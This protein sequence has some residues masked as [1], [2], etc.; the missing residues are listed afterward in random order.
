MP[1]RLAIVGLVVLCIGM[2]TQAKADLVS[3]PF[4]TTTP[5]PSTLTD[6]TSSLSFPQFDSSLGTLTSVELSLT[7]HFSTV[8]TV[9][10]V[11]SSSST[12][13]AK[14][15]V[16]VTVQDSGGNL[17]IPELDLFSSNYAFT[18][19]PAGQYITSGTINKSGGSSDVYTSPAVLAEFTGPGTIVL[20]AATYTQS[21]IA[22]SGGNS[23]AAQVTNADLT[24]SVKYTYIPVPEPS[25][26]LLLGIGTLGLLCCT[27]RGRKS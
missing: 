4:T 16:Q 3:G 1:H 19:L 10:N 20:P 25:T 21:W 27:R 9:T 18:N 26:I 12:G 14:T 23:L 24:G 7:G 17:L 6:W 15:E 2:A 22:Y 5:I 8:I 11:G 13:T